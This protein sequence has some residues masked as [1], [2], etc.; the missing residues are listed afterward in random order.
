MGVAPEA[1]LLEGTGEVRALGCAGEERAQGCAGEE[2]AQGC[3]LEGTGEEQAWRA[4]V[5]SRH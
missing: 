4:L 5:R 2:R 3:P 1:Q